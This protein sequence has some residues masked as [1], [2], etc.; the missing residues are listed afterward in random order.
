MVVSDG[1]GRGL[2]VGVAG[3]SGFLPGSGSGCDGVVVGDT[4]RLQRGS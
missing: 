4:E 2:V 1:V 3:V